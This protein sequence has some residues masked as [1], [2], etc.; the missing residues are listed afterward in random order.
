[1]LPCLEDPRPSQQR[2]VAPPDAR[3]V[4]PVDS[5]AIELTPVEYFK[6]RRFRASKQGST[7][8]ACIQCMRLV[9]AK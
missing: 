3:E 6:S 7:M 9:V 4:A 8:F 1:M 5:A 2:T